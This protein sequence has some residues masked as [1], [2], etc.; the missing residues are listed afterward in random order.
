ML[1]LSHKRFVRFM[2]LYFKAKQFNSIVRQLCYHNIAHSW[3]PD[4]DTLILYHPLF[5][6]RSTTAPVLR[7]RSSSHLTKK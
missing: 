6:P 4:G 7:R 3:A 5:S 2:P 1:E